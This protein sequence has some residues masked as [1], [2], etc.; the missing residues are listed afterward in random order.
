MPTAH[1]A[2]PGPLRF[3]F[4]YALAA[5]VV[6]GA[7]WIFTDLR[8]FEPI[9]ALVAIE[10]LAIWC[11]LGWIPAMCIGALAAG[12]QVVLGR[13]AQA[14]RIYGVVLMLAAVVTGVLWTQGM[15]ISMEVETI[16]VDT[17]MYSRGIREAGEATEPGGVGVYLEQYF[18]SRSRFVALRTLRERRS[19]LRVGERW[20]QEDLDA[21]DVASLAG[22]NSTHKPLRSLALDT[23]IWVRLEGLKAGGFEAVLHA[24]EIPP[25]V[26]MEWLTDWEK[27]GR[28]RLEERLS[29]EDHAALQDWAAA[30]LPDGLPALR[31]S[32]EQGGQGAVG[33]FLSRERT[34][35]HLAEVLRSWCTT[36]GW[37]PLLDHP[38]PSAADFAALSAA[39][40][41]LLQADDPVLRREADVLRGWV[42]TRI[43][44]WKRIP[45]L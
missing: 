35:A 29:P 30:R 43:P 28:P 2:N 41:K 17:A 36:E 45:G 23:L 18:A 6:M 32:L 16:R 11:S 26:L 15:E 44:K 13:H 31:W 10:S 40:D 33:A 19:E 37:S 21:L 38:G 22:L 14:R 7:L 39:L 25:S 9:T 12:W 27:P 42:D 4:R 34:D 5:F 1:R 24:E 3:F 20:P 8:Q